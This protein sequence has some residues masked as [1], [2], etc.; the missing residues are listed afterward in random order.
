[1]REIRQN[2]RDPWQITNPMVD[3]KLQHRHRSNDLWVGFRQG[4]FTMRWLVT[5]PAVPTAATRLA[6]RGLPH[7]LAML[8]VLAAPGVARA[9]LY[10]LSGTASWT[11]GGSP[12]PSFDVTGV[13]DLHAPTL[14]NMGPEAP[15]GTDRYR[16]AYLMEYTFFVRGERLSGAGA[17]VVDAHGC[18]LFDCNFYAPIAD[19]SANLGAW[20]SS[21][22]AFFNV[23]GTPYP[24]M[25]LHSLAY[26]AAPEIIEFYDT[27][28]NTRGFADRYLLRD[29]LVATRTAAV[30]EPS[31]LLLLGA[32]LA[33]LVGRRS[34]RR[35]ST[36]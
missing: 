5:C 29:T 35:S 15:D 9:D 20:V 2:P 8:F 14:I 12:W 7:L 17:M 13:L 6:K 26:A 31:T 16:V 23:G 21:N 3:V 32:G 1:L 28:L 22:G 30:P 34:L 24:D 27:D 4:A 33:G 25:L 11:G 19:S 18:G 36:T 10:T